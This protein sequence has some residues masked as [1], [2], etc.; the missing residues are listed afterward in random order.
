V[1][2][3]SIIITILM[4]ASSTSEIQGS[5]FQAVWDNNPGDSYHQLLLP[6]S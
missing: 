5:F 3:A 4:E 1:L 6:I 2:A